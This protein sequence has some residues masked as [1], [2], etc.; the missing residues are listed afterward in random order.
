MRL[1]GAEALL[2]QRKEAIENW[3][4]RAIYALDRD[5]A[6]PQYVCF[7][8]LLDTLRE[9]GARKACLLPPTH[10]E[11]DRS[12]VA[13]SNVTYLIAGRLVKDPSP[14]Q[15]RSM[16]T[17]DRALLRACAR[18]LVP[19]YCPGACEAVGGQVPVVLVIV[20]V[21]PRCPLRYDVMAV[22]P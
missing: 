13:R 8:A 15:L 12:C 11:F 10:D 14:E 5:W 16:T 22:Q 2:P 9:A 1:H 20:V 4:V 17:G 19:A 18:L 21:L 6:S 3:H 7:R